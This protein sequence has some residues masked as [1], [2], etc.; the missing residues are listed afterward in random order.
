M[1]ESGSYCARGMAAHRIIE[2][3]QT[4]REL[5][6]HYLCKLIR[7]PHHENKWRQLLVGADDEH[8]L[9][10]AS[11]VVPAVRALY[12]ATD[13]NLPFTWQQAFQVSASS[14]F[15][16]F[17]WKTIQD[18][19][20]ELH[21]NFDI[22]SNKHSMLNLCFKRSEHGRTLWAAES[23][24]SQ[25]EALMMQF[26]SWARADV[27]HLTVEKSTEWVNEQLLQDWTLE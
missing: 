5:I 19:Y 6:I 9:E 2:V 4:Y 21:H 27:E 15:D 12:E 7:A 25:D 20:L 18:W 22:N 8:A 14:L 23:P 17:H 10:K 16:K 24:F 11:F 3:N 1:S 26:K 13:L